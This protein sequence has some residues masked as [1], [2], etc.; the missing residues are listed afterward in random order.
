MLGEAGVVGCRVL[1]VS[2]EVWEGER[3]GGLLEDA[4]APSL[5]YDADHY[6]VASEQVEKSM[7]TKRNVSDQPCFSSP[8]FADLTLAAVR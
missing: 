7:L 5:K 3:V 4:W 8:S 2:E 1:R 6:C